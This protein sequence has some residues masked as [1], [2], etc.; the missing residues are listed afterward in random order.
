MKS[1]SLKTKVLLFILVFLTATKGF[2]QKNNYK[3]S[4]IG[5]N[6]GLLTD[7]T[8]EV[9]FKRQFGKNF[10]TD[11]SLGGSPQTNNNF[12]N[13]FGG[14]ANF[15]Q[16]IPG[17][18]DPRYTYSTVQTKF[19]GTYAKVSLLAV[20][21][22][23]FNTLHSN[24]YKT[25][26]QFYIGPMVGVSKFNNQSKF[27]VN[28]NQY[29]TS[30]SSNNINSSPPL[31]MDIAEKGKVYATGISLGMSIINVGPMSFDFGIDGL[32]YKRKSNFSDVNHTIGLGSSP[33][34]RLNYVF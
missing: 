14:N 18:N 30:S 32:S 34:L 29:S 1:T 31:A 19:A 33:V 2:T 5:L 7:N 28:T 12:I 22:I 15:S 10:R 9:C 16:K 11:I 26:M 17:I 24:E 23:R 3:Q 8:F 4:S 27:L 25:Y 21:N 20:A 13:S 6:A